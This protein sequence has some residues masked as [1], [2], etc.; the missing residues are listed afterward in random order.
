MS[1]KLNEEDVLE[2]LSNEKDKT[3]DTA[4][5][6]GEYYKWKIDKIKEK[7]QSL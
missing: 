1:R 4:T 5:L 2:I 7:I 3:K 6:S